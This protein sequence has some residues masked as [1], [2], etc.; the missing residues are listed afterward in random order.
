M[1]KD[2]K[3]CQACSQY[4]ENWT[5]NEEEERA[6]NKVVQ[7]L[8]NAGFNVRRISGIGKAEAQFP[9][10]RLKGAGLGITA[11]IGSEIMAAKNPQY[12]TFTRTATYLGGGVGLMLFGETPL[13]KALGVTVAGSSVVPVILKI[14]GKS[15]G[16][17][18]M[19]LEN[20]AG[21][22]KARVGNIFNNRLFKRSDYIEDATVIETAY[23]PGVGY[24]E[25]TGINVNAFT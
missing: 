16:K 22:L 7:E 18:T 21:E 12:G 25:H 15:I 9:A 14:T 4:G 10:E 2:N 23:I 17:V 19:D 6:I 13:V 24:Q 11:V 5:P 20:F 8:E 1:C 3:K